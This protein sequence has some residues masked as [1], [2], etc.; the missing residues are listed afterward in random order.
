[1][2]HDNHLTTAD[3]W[4]GIWTGRQRNQGVTRTKERLRHTRTWRRL[5]TELLDSTGR[6]GP[7]DVLEL[8]CAPGRMLLE[9]H[10]LRPGHRYSG[11]DYAPGGLEAAEKLLAAA[12]I[13]ATLH[14]GDIRTA[15]VPP[16][17]LAVSFGLVEH[18][19]EPADA[20]GY[21]RRFLRPG[22][23]AAITVPNYAHPLTA[24][25]M[26]RFCPETAA[27]HNLAIMSTDS[28]RAA[29]EAAGFTDVRTGEAGGPLLPSSQVRP[30]SLGTAYG[31]A[32]RAWNLASNFGP[33]GW[34]W[35]AVVWG[36]GVS[37]SPVD[38]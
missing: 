3:T 13:P 27:T 6:T 28:M 22:G 23:T 38:A 19:T 24:R 5:L 34:P 14:L 18:F 21:H 37:P 4:D 7:V 20:V 33:E 16:A 8:G 29:F 32:S 17:D 9:L 35:A 12:G 25:L 26:R 2:S 10:G 11:I 31:L 15:T 1:M 30:G 36:T